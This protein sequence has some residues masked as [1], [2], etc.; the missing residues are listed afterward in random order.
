MGLQVDGV[1]LA[2]CSDLVTGRNVLVELVDSLWS[3]QGPLVGRLGQGKV[4]MLEKLEG[5]LAIEGQG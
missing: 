4:A 3:G 2:G 1:L 5:V